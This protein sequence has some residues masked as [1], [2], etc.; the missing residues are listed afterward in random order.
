MVCD[1]TEL[2]IDHWLWWGG[3]R[4][5]LFR[6]PDRRHAVSVFGW[7]DRGSLF[8]GST[9]VGSHASGRRLDHAGCDGVHGEWDVAWAY[10]W[11]VSR[12]HADLLSHA[13]A[14]QYRGSA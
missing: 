3:L 1:R 5:D 7:Y 4:L 12:L 2:S 9:S 11:S 6:R 14:V 8:S 13:G 10:Q